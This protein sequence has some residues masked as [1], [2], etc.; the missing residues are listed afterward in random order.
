MIREILEPQH[1][2]IVEVIA[3]MKNNLGSSQEWAKE[4]ENILGIVEMKIYEK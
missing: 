3:K 4:L 1:H 2:A